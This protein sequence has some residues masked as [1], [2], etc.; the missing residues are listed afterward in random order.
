MPCFFQED[1]AEQIICLCNRWQ[2]FILRCCRLLEITIGYNVR[3]SPARQKYRDVGCADN[4]SI[5]SI[6]LLYSTNQN[7]NHM[8]KCYHARK[9]S[10]GEIVAPLIAIISDGDYQPEELIWDC[11]NNS[12]W[13][14]E[15]EDFRSMTNHKGIFNVEFTPE[16]RGF[17]NDDLI[18]EMD[19][20]F[21]VALDIGWK[22]FDTFDEAFNY[23]KENSYWCKV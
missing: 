14:E 13:W 16:Y 19:G 11:C 7:Y 10:E 18:I 12:C 23:C 6:I 17:C 1:G 20:G 3:E 2:R 22:K 5:G 21:Y 15:D 9:G 8:I 4:C